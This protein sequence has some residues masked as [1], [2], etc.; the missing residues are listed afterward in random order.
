M[1]EK[2]ET[3]E[4]RTYTITLDDDGTVQKI[5]GAATKIE[6]MGFCSVQSLLEKIDDLDPVA[7]FVDIKLD[8]MSSGLD[9][10]PVIKKK[11]P[12]IPILVITSS[13]NDEVL[14]CALRSGAD[15]LIIKPL[16]PLELNA[17]FQLRLREAEIR[18]NRNEVK[19]N[20]LT[21]NTAHGFVRSH[22]GKR[23]LSPTEL[24]LLTTLAQAVDSV[25]PRQSLKR[26]CW[27]RV[28]VSEG[29][30]DRKVHE[31]RKVIKDLSQDLQLKT[32]YGVGISL[33]STSHAE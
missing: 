29:A 7:V 14:N 33:I 10:I 15:D 8:I 1:N 13:T 4:R 11:W 25:V 3:N 24:N 28:S 20:D 30:L 21:I 22:K 6:S 19:C 5:I 26:Q 17:R 18:K 12:Q 31:V 23:N 2:I 16:R 32:V 9:V 27:G